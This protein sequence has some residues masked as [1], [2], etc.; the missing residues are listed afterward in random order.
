MRQNAIAVPEPFS[1]AMTGRTHHMRA[2]SHSASS[3][4]RFLEMRDSRKRRLTPFLDPEQVVVD[5]V[6]DPSVPG[7]FNKIHYAESP[8]FAFAGLQSLAR[9]LLP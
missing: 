3:M 1:P 2:I 5:L 8:R 6:K 9:M 7:I 4:S